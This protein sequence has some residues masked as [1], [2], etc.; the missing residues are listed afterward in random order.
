MRTLR[1]LVGRGCVPRV[2]QFSMLCTRQKRFHCVSIFVRPRSVV[3]EPDRHLRVAAEC[4]RRVLQHDG[5]VEAVSRRVHATCTEFRE[6]EP[7]AVLV[8]AGELCAWLVRLILAAHVDEDRIVVRERRRRVGGRGRRPAA[9][10]HRGGEQD[11][12]Q[13]NAH[14]A[15]DRRWWLS[16]ATSARERCG[17]MLRER[18]SNVAEELGGIGRRHHG[19]HMLRTDKREVLK[20]R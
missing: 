9:N 3:V 15:F 18:P 20:L 2:R 13:G 5:H 1:L 12:T 11:S 8:G 19:T 6:D 16:S 10:E 4:Q 7:D 14:A 17:R